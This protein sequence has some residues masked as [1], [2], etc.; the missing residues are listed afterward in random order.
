MFSRLWNLCGYQ[1]KFH[2]AEHR[3]M[4]SWDREPCRD[5]DLA[6]MNAA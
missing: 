5:G 4:P 3:I 6:V 1:H 2:Y